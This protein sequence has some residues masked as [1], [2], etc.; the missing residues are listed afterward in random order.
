MIT[1]C[2]REYIRMKEK[3]KSLTYEQKGKLLWGLATVYAGCA[4][5]Y[6]LNMAGFAAQ[7]DG[8]G[9]TQSAL[10]VLVFVIV[11]YFWRSVLCDFGRISDA[12]AKRRRLLFALLFGSLLGLSFI[13]G[14]EIRMKGMTPPGYIAKLW[15]LIMALGLGVAF[16]PLTSKWFAFQDDRKTKEQREELPKGTKRKCFWYSWL[17]IVVCWIP[18][19]LAYYPAIM[20]YDFHRQ[21]AEAYNGYIWF[22][23]HHPLIHTFL[24]RVFLLLGDALGSYEIGMAIFSALQMLILAAVLAYSCNVIGRITL[25]VWPV[26][27]MAVIYGILPVHPILAM[28]MTKDILFTAFFLLLVLLIWERRHLVSLQDGYAVSKRKRTVLWAAI[29]LTGILTMLLRN[30][31]VYAFVVFAVFYVLI[32]AGERLRIAILCA[33]I[34]VCGMGCK[35]GIREAMDA[36]KGSTS[37]MFSVMMQQFARVGSRQS[38][39]L[40]EEDYVIINKYVPEELWSN[41]N[42]AIADSVK[43]MIA[44]YYYDA[45]KEDIPGMLVDWVKIGVRYPNEYIDAFLALTSGYWFLDD[46][47]HAEVL[48]YGA[49]TNLGLLYT[50]NASNTDVFEGVESKSFLPGLLERY[51]KIVNGNSYYGWPVVSI[52]FKPAFYCWLLLLVMVSWWYRKESQKQLLLLLPLLYLMTLVLGPVVNFRYIYPVMVVVPVLLAEVLKTQEKE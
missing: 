16:M 17:G 11:G 6:L 19:F 10:S 36:G 27:M 51:Q 47:S 28:S 4:V 45:W 48:G 26:V 23:D 20:S 5:C 49:D 46:V 2:E 9:F 34:V 21:S 29:L 18:V 15:D 13:W 31:A 43:G 8:T 24:I 1:N 33:A 52:L 22:N 3:M 7:V 44:A 40:T 39:V 42:P 35:A 41:Y 32:S 50:F 38:Q 37:E 12:K 30:N 25:R 14:Y